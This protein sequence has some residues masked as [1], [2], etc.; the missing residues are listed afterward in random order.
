[1]SGGVVLLHPSPFFSHV[2]AAPCLSQS[3]AK[4][5]LLPVCFFVS[6]SPLH[7]VLVSVVPKRRRP[8]AH[9]AGVSVVP[10]RRRPPRPCGGGLGGPKAEEAPYA[11]VAGVWVV[12]K[13]RRPP[14]PCGG[15][16]KTEEAPMPRGPQ[17]SQSGGGPHTHVVEASVVPKRRRPP[18][19]C[20]GGLGGPKT[21]ETPTPMR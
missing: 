18:H 8:H 4:D 11:H 3:K 13:R 19:P 15:G 21:E 7:A 9:A 20:G 1:M 5:V 17:W 10:K 2:V 6:V 12:P 16:P 14:R